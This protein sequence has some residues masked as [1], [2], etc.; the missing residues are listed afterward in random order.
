VVVAGEGGLVVSGG[1][2]VD[3]EGLGFVGHGANVGA[4]AGVGWI[5][6]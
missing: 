1:A 5:C 2:A 3:V 4:G 6:G